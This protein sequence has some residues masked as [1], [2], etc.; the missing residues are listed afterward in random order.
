MLKM[1]TS[2]KDVGVM[3]WIKTKN[4]DQSYNPDSGD[5]DERLKKEMMKMAI[6]K[7]L[8]KSI[9]DMNIPGKEVMPID[10]SSEGTSSMEEMNKLIIEKKIQKK[11]RD[12]LQ[13]F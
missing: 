3:N 13:N 8:G 9:Q 5:E 7:K 10:K 12:A 2:P 6:E 11:L 4:K 1:W